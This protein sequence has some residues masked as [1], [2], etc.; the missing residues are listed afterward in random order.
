M[1]KKIVIIVSILVFFWMIGFFVFAYRINRFENATHIKADAIVALTG[2]RNRIAQAVAMLNDGAAEKLLI[3]GVSKGYSL[4]RLQNRAD[5]HI[6]TQ[7]EIA[8]DEKSTNTVENAIEAADWINKHSVSSIILVTSNYH[9]PR[10][11]LEF[12]AYNPQLLINGYSVVSEKVDKKWWRSW[13]SF[14]LLFIEYNKLLVV[15][16]KYVL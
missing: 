2:G 5:V 7:R 1:I 6:A 15:W 4:K 12:R 11:L 10:S 3:S 8:L 9:L 13:N 14:C 16:A